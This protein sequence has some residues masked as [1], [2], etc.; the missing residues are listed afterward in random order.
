MCGIAGFWDLKKQTST[1]EAEALAQQM[2]K[3]INHRGPDGY[4]LYWDEDTNVMLTHRRLAIIDLNPT[5]HQP[6][7][8][9]NKTLSL[10]F[11]GEIYN[12]QELRN[13]LLQLGVQFRG[14]SDTEVLLEG[15]KIWGVEQTLQKAEGMFAFCLLDLKHRKV[16]LGR[17]RIGEKPLYF[18]QHQDKMYFSSELKAIFDLGLRPKLSQDSVDRFLSYG[19]IPGEESILAGFKKIKPAHFVV[20]DLE[21][22]DQKEVCYWNYQNQWMQAKNKPIASFDEAKKLLKAELTRVVHDQMIADVPLGA[23]LSGGIDSSLVVA[24]MAQ[25]SKSK[26]KTFTIGFDDKSINE[27]HFAKKVSDILGTEHTELYLDNK[28]LLN[29]IAKLPRVYDE[30]F[31]DAS[32]IPT[33]LVSK[34][35][36]EKVTVS[37]SG[38]GGDELFAGY[39]RYQSWEQLLAKYQKTPKFIRNFIAAALRTSDQRRFSKFGSILMSDN[40]DD[41]YD[42]FLR[43]WISNYEYKQQATHLKNAN[44]FDRLQALDIQNYLPD[45]IFVKVDR[46]SMAHSLETRAPFLNHK[47]L[48]LSWKIPFEF[49]V[50][51]GESKYILKEILKDYLPEELINRPKQGF[52][53]PMETWLRTSLKDWA[54]DLIQNFESTDFI[55]KKQVLKVW[56][57]HQIGINNSGLLWDVIVLQDWKK[58]YG[59]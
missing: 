26:V 30:P 13:S 48:E 39:D 38:D 20:F 42:S 55:S 21:S 6:M 45:D 35:C 8:D 4:G 3:A 5:G 16:F 46:A 29:V 44:S 34:L 1:N 17:D 19:Y 2:I 43:H 15:F 25:L 53:V 54:Y 24:T 37:L 41:M 58:Q 22:R 12:Y 47:M 14:K 10:V 50:H 36:R 56:N 59:Y 27:A 28:D 31:A 52:G 51:Q 32:Q 7:F 57:Q 9:Q 49:K 18:G 23:F 11:N 40:I 33:Y